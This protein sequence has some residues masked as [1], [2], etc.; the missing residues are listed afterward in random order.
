MKSYSMLRNKSL[1]L[2]NLF[3]IGLYS[4]RLLGRFVGM[5]RRLKASYE[6][7]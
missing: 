2:Q 1:I 6:P 4:G 7:F 3:M 5:S